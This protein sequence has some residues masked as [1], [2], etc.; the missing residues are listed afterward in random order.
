[1]RKRDS[2]G[3]T[4]QNEIQTETEI[5][6]KKPKM[7]KVIIHND[8]YT[9][10]DFVVEVLMSVFNKQ[11]ADATRIMLEVHQKGAGIA[12]IYTYDIAQTKIAEVHEM[13]K[14]K[15]FPLL[16]SLEEE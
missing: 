7:Y 8:N 3:Q 10:M 11:A 4:F 13:A 5:E 6:V 15:E 1:M 9:T 12:G 16:C 14:Q 2:M